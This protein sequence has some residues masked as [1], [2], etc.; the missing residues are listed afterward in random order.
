[1]SLG[2]GFAQNGVIYLAIESQGVP[3]GSIQSK[4]ILLQTEPQFMLLVTGGM[5]HWRQIVD[6]YRIQPSID[7]ARDEI[8]RLLK[9][10]T[11]LPNEACCLLCGFEAMTPTCWRIN[12]LRNEH[13]SSCPVP[14]SSV[15]PI[16]K[17]ADI[18]TCYAEKE[19]AQGVNPQHALRDAIQSVLQTGDEVRGPVQSISFSVA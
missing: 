19:L 14:L 16:G 17:Y 4:L 3:H 13:L 10:F 11:C 5:E 8:V 1:M 2:L 7:L 6:S 15:Q 12:K 9:Q 18:A